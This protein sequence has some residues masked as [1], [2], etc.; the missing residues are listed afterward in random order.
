MFPCLGISKHCSKNHD[1]YYCYKKQ[2]DVHCVC[3]C[4]TEMTLEEL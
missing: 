2:M 3:V 1:L 4:V